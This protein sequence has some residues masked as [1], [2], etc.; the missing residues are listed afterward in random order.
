MGDSLD[1]RDTVVLNRSRTFSYKKLVLIGLPFALLVFLLVAAYWLLHTDPGASWIWNKVEN[2]G[3]FV[4]SSSGTDGNLADGFKIQGLAYRS[5]D[6][7]VLVD[8]AE[9]K[10]GPG[11]WPLSI[12]VQTLSLLDV[13][14]VSHPLN[15]P[16]KDVKAEADISSILEVL[17]LPIPLKI[18]DALLTNISLHEGDEPPVEIVNTLRFKATLDEQLSV[19]QLDITAPRFEAGIHAQ[20]AL[21]SPHDLDVAAQGRLQVTGEGAANELILPFTLESSG[22]L[23]RILFDIASPENGLNLDGELLEPFERLAW[24]INGTLHHFDWSFGDSGETVTLS[25]LTL[26]SQGRIDDWSVGLESMVQSGDLQDSRFTLSGTGSETGIRVSNAGLAGPGV[27]LDLSGELDW[28][29]QA[30]T[31]L[32]A[33]IGQLDLSPWIADW[34]EGEKLVGGFE[35]NWSGAGMEIS[36]GTL[37]LAGTELAVN[38]EADIDIDANS[39]N[40]RL[41][42]SDLIWPLRGATPNFSSPS[43]GLSIH[44]SV[45][46]WTTTGQLLL[47]I[48]DYPQGRFDIEGDGQRTS[49][50][51]VILSGQV[52]GGNVSGDA[53][54]DWNEG[55]SWDANIRATNI[56]PEPL[57]PGWPGR[58]DTALAIEAQHQPDRYNIELKS[59]DGFLRGVELNGQ[60]SLLIDD[61]KLTF[62]RFELRTDEATLFLDGASTD[63]AGLSMKFSGYLPSLLLQGARGQLQLEGRYSSHVDQAVLDMQMEA[64]DLYWNDFGIR[65]LAINTQGNG[66]GGVIPPI[67]LNASGLTWQDQSIDELSLSLSPEG[68]KHRLRAELAG[69]KFALDAAMTLEPQSEDRFFDSPWRG[70]LDTFVISLNQLHGFELLEPAPFEWSTESTQLDPVCLQD[71]VGAGV[72]LSGG[73]Q[74]TGD[75]SVF[76]DVK[77]VPVDYLREILEL[78]VHFDQVIEGQLEWHQPRDQPAN[79]GAEFRITAGRIFEPDDESS[80]LESNEGKFGFVLQNGNLESGHLDIEFPGS[81][82]VDF[83]FEVQ[84]IA[85]DGAR[86]LTGRAVTRINNI[87]LFGHLAWPALDD[88]GGHFES[89]IQM[90]GNLLDPDFSGGF[91]F[92]NGFVQ[93][94]P[95]GVKLEEIEFEGQVEKRDRGQLKGQFRAGEGIGTISGDFLFEDFD[96]LKMN[97][98]FSGDRLLLVNTDTVKFNTETDLRFNLSPNR[99]DI[100]GRINV[101]SARLTPANLLLDKVTDSED[102]VIE[103]RDTGEQPEAKKAGAGNLVF[104][105]LEVAFGDD[106]F[107]KVPGVETYINGSVLYSWSGDPVP[108][109]NGNYILKGKV[110]VYG[111]TLLIRNGSISFPDVPANNPL[112]NIRAEREIYGN[113]QIGAAGVQ[114]IGT[115]KR[116]K[117]EAY[118]MP[119]TNEDRAWT[120]LVTGS[121]FDQAQGVSGFDV[122]TYIAP[123]L[124]VSYGIS[125][126][127]DENVVSARYD[128]KKGFGVKVTS[129]QRETGLDMS[130][131]IEK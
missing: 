45:D 112:L 56:D 50:R 107:I 118:T 49:A 44:G 127:E 121:D 74:S 2:S 104:G 68:E 73:Y 16:G 84:N 83:D 100:N 110:D 101:P 36:Q 82:F 46:Q 18:H 14:I 115:L 31:R 71:K 59:L 39:V 15:T 85:E 33:V 10:A 66:T 97:L 114:V 55:M 99:M 23:E 63:P 38:L 4:V 102:L 26:I 91:K 52:L 19:H 9:I 124:Y 48:G 108:L 78:D 5:A 93:Y 6:I 28:S 67:Q 106:V 90:G 65:A 126:F 117:I 53:G 89:D 7:D 12:Q 125:L 77:A 86:K 131:T 42:W 11:W 95:L 27:E 62:N 122:G 3:G 70:L 40:A 20:L 130:Y 13:S 64:L 111:P 58:L 72:C 105:Q 80:L 32:S 69:E 24:D 116:P 113:T 129:G 120:L 75:W 61:D 1:Y 81:G 25:G 21:E 30:E 47:R 103:S 98:A 51:L 87:K 8:H 41:E 128:L 43:G 119:V 22:N 94:I 37:S 96:N 34:P 60:G 79:G 88:I 92:S 17:K 54:I 29:P 35:L 57:L 76:A 123:K 109:A